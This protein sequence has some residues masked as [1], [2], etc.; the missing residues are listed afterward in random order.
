M[1]AA[2]SSLSTP[3]FDWHALAPD[4]VLVATLVVL[5][6]AD[7]LLPEREAWRTSTI[8]AIGLLASRDTVTLSAVLSR[9]T[10]RTEC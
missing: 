6:V 2:A 5:L 10:S 8:A 7:L 3:V 9:P 1:L 4:I